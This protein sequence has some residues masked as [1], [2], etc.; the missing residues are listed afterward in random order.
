MKYLIDTELRN[1]I[2]NY[3]ASRPYAEVFNAIQALQNLQPFEPPAM[4]PSDMM[5]NKQ[6]GLSE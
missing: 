6:A 5:V 3:L 4:T 2:L 1:A